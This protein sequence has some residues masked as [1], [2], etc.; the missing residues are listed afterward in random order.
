MA[1]NDTLERAQEQK[2]KHLAAKLLLRPG[3]RVLDI[4]SGWGGLALYLA[5]VPGAEVTGLTCQLAVAEPDRRA[6]DRRPATADSQSSQPHLKQAGATWLNPA[7]L[8][9]DGRRRRP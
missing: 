1:P 4:G 7:G 3:R 9:G 5:C 6:A 8:A 2:K